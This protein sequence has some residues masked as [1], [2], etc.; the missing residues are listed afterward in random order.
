MLQKNL[1]K[2]NMMKF[3]GYMKKLYEGLTWEKK[4]DDEDVYVIHLPGLKSQI[5][6]EMMNLGSLV[7]IPTELY[8]FDKK[9]YDRLEV[10]INSY[11]NK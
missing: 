7:N 8:H 10:Q 5:K 3:I 1:K 2:A 11:F 6:V 9:A 4:S